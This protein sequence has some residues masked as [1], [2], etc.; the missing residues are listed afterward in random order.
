[1]KGRVTAE[2]VSSGRQGQA[3]RNRR[4]TGP[5]RLRCGGAGRHRQSLGDALCVFVCVR[6]RWRGKERERERERE[7]ELYLIKL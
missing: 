3:G 7:R 1:M 4:E 5:L 2:S 6:E